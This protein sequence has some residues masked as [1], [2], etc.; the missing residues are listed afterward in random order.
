M[1]FLRHQF[2]SRKRPSSASFI[3]PLPEPKIPKTTATG[4]PPSSE[5]NCVEED[6]PAVAIDK[7]VS[8]LADAGCTLINP[9]G[10][11]CLPSDP[12]KLRSHLDRLFSASHEGRALRSHFLAGFSSFI[13]SPKNLRRVLVA[14]NQ[15][16]GRSESLMRQLLLVPAIQ[17]DLQILILEKI[18]EYFDVDPDCSLEDDVARLIINHFRWLDFMVDCSAFLEKLMQVLLICPL[19]FKKEIIGSLPE[20]IGDQSNKAVFD[21]L[22]QMVR[23]DSS[24]IM[25]VLDCFSNLNLDDILQEQVITIAISYIKTIDGEH[26]P[27]LLR[28]LLL[29]ATPLNVRR[30]V[31]HIREQLKFIGTSHAMQHKK[32][33]GKSLMASTEASILDALR[34]GL[35]SKSMLCQEILKVLISL[36]KPQDHK[37]TDLWLLVL[38][39]MNGKSMKKSIE[40]I[41]RKKVVENCIQKVMIDQC[42]CGNRELVQDYFPPFLSLSEYFLT[43]RE[44]KARDFGTHIYMCLFGEFGDTYCRQEVLSSLV[45]H[46]GSGVSFEV[47]SALETMAFMASKYAQELIPLSTHING[48]LDYLEAFNIEN[49]HKVYEIFSHLALL[50]RS[51]EECFGSSFG[52]ELLMILRKQVNHPD[53]KYKKMGLIG[54]LKVVSCLADVTKVSGTSFEKTNC[55]EALELLRT[56]LDSSKHFCLPL[57]LF[58]DELTVMLEHKRLQP[59]I[60]EW[61]AKHIGEFESMFLSDLDGGQLHSADAYGGLEG[62]LWMNLDGDIS[63]VCLSIFPLASSSLQ[64][65]TSL[66]VLPAYFLLLSV[67]ERLTNQGSL[68]GIDALLGCPLHLPA[69]KYFS[70]AG[71]QSLTAKQKQIV[72]LSLYYAINWIRELLNAFCTQV[73][74]G[75]ECIS[76]VTKEDIIAKLLKRLRNLVFLESLLNNS[77]RSHPMSLP[78]LHLHVQHSGTSLFDNAYDMMH[79]EINNKHKKTHD[80]ISPNKN[81]HNKVSTQSS[82]GTNRKLQ[83]PTIFEM[84]RKG[85]AVSSKQLVHEDSS[86][87]PLKSLNSAD[88]ESDSTEQLI[89]E[90]PAASKALNAQRCKFRPLLMQCF[91]LLEFSKKQDSCCSDPTAEVDYFT[92]TKQ[93]SS[94]CTNPGPGFCR[95][96]VKEFLTKIRPLFPN[97]RRHFDRAVSILK[98]EGTQSHKYEQ[99]ISGDEHCE[100][101]WK[102]HS[103][104]AG[105]PEIAKLGI[106]NYSMSVSVSKEILHCFSK[107][108]NLPEVQGEKTI[109]S[110]LLEAFQ[111]SKISEIV[112][113]DIQPR[114]LPG[115]MEYLYL[116][117]ASFLEDVLSKA[118]SS[119]FTLASECLFTLESI[120]ASVQIFLNKLE[121]NVES[122]H[123]ISIDRILP[124][125]QSILGTS[126]Q[127]LLQHKWDDMSLENGWKNKGEIM[128]KILFIYMENSE[129]KS[130]L[131]DELACSILPEV[132]SCKTMTEHDNHGFSTLCNETFAMWYRVMHEENLAI[133]NSLVKDVIL[134][135][136][137]AGVQ[138]EMVENHLIK[139][140]RSV[141]VV[142]S[143][144]STCRTHDKVIVRAMAVKYGG[145]FVDSFLKVF[146]FLQAHFRTHSEI[147]IQLVKELQKATRTIQTLCSEAKGSKQIAITSKIPPTKRSIE[148]FLFHVKALLH[149]TPTACTFWMGNLK[150]KNLRGEVVSSQVYAD[151]QNSNSNADEDL[152]EA[153]DSDQPVNIGSEEDKDIE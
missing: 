6:V 98:E 99:I 136:T 62:E 38:I 61:I 51:S 105:N 141:N 110:D 134:R 138:L 133:L 33:K 92:P 113:S 46:V 93:F 43:C 52:N 70:V 60:I 137:G 8:I 125:L 94:R 29:N 148:R 56:S 120:V 146:E 139:I 44:Q 100:E 50:A 19:H 150:H 124:T 84:L 123:P 126:A 41:F 47:T 74:R 91:S 67:V 37:I 40:K 145:K 49:L 82:S 34:T 12:L 116:G 86:G 128:Q 10:P 119:S 25:S 21:S 143:L 121:R 75:F 73:A 3:S 54:T 90:V 55:Q 81:R 35:L 11:P 103:S 59:E 132:P 89:L 127:K 130:D 147:I 109:L 53:L 104:L 7:M 135:K 15:C 152:A 117:A 30:I 4:S 36:E 71:W 2:P 122:T 39:Y 5:N 63:P 28:F 142:V 9:S 149:T 76:Q 22:G 57:I 24:I 95:M 17:L 16:G 107:M 14:S 87:Q 111:P 129:S 18:P 65:T 1:V 45:T 13:D 78:E 66:Q 112:F 115:T 131:L 153:E 101:H 140:Q 20:I 80:T 85:G 23:E 26:M 114:P 102:V 31:L 88:Q 42:I 27:H 79:A 106:S 151:D 77:I 118:C 97:L 48:I 96:A 83:Q 58:Y 68:G 64:S 72:C 69:S 32:L 144:V 108:L